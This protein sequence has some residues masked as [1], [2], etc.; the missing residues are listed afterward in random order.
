MLVK[1]LKV[2]VK[3]SVMK[4]D[5]PSIHKNLVPISNSIENNLNQDWNSIHCC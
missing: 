1:E 2:T 4:K 5:F 3:G